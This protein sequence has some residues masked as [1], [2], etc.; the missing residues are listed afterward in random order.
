[1][2]DVELILKVDNVG[3]VTSIKETELA[4]AEL[5]NTAEGGGE[6]QI[7]LLKKQI[8][9]LQEFKKKTKEAEATQEEYNEAM[10][11]TAST[12]DKAG[13]SVGSVGKRLGSLAAIIT[14]VVAGLRSLATAFKETNAGMNIMIK[15]GSVFRQL[16][17]DIVTLNFRNGDSMKKG[18]EIAKMEIALRRQQIAD[19]KSLANYQVIYNRYMADANNTNK[20][21]LDRVAALTSATEV[22]NTIM[23]KKVANAREEWLLANDDLAMKPKNHKLQQKTNELYAAYVLLQ[24]E[25]IINNERLQEQELGIKSEAYQTAK[26]RYLAEIQAVNDANDEKLKKEKEFLEMKK[27]LQ[28]TYDEA[29]IDS[30]K[31]VELLK[32]EKDA[33]NLILMTWRDEL[34]KAGKLDGEMI[35]Q[36]NYLSQKIEETFE[37]G[38]IE[39]AKQGTADLTSELIDIFQ[40]TIDKAL[41][42]VAGKIQPYKGTPAKSQTTIWDTL[43]LN[44]DTEEGQRNIN[45]ARETVDMIVGMLDSLYTKRVEDATRNRELYDQRISELQQEV[46]RELEIT[47]MGYASDLSLK[48]QQLSKLKTERDKALLDEEKAIDRQRKLQLI[49]QE[50]SL[51]SSAAKL[52]QSAIEDKGVLGLILAAAEVATMFLMFAEYKDQAKQTVQLGRGGS[53]DSTGMITGKNHSEGGEHFLDHVEVEGGEKWGVLSK[54]ASGKY[55]KVFDYMVDSFNKD[56]VPEVFTNVANVVNVD[57]NGS[58]SRLDKVIEEQRKLNDKWGKDQRVIVEGNKRIITR[59]NKIRIIG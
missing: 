43:G 18:L 24:Q 52:I 25:Q 12:S 1:M 45:N 36:L 19:I 17:Y 31:G 27:K 5:K 55:G 6:D 37:K 33:A 30:L 22:Y 11:Q 44:P 16:M 53:G 39:Y 56:K 21:A 28:E 15:T 3:A 20:N 50:I 57:N 14:L 2:A 49:V 47:R 35:Q 9:I 13:A 34:I 46:N 4:L 51:A 59:G 32:A 29:R 58:N 7:T 26:E 42:V 40:P 10:D 23:T 41:S 38:I 48:Q 8:S 54:R